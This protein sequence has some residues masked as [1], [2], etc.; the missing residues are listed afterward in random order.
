MN[1]EAEASNRVDLEDITPV[2]GSEWRLMPL[3]N[4]ILLL[5]I[6]ETFG[7][8]GIQLMKYP[9]VVLSANSP[10]YW[11]RD[12]KTTLEELES[13]RA[14][15]RIE[16][17][18]DQQLEIARNLGLYAFDPKLEGQYQRDLIMK[19][20]NVFMSDHRS[21][22]PTPSFVSSAIPQESAR[23]LSAINI[24]PG[25][26]HF[27]NLGRGIFG[28]NQK[29]RVLI[30]RP[31]LGLTVDHDRDEIL[32]FGGTKAFDVVTSYSINEF[33]ELG[34]PGPAWIDEVEISRGKVRTEIPLDLLTKI[35]EHC[36]S[37]FK[38]NL[39]GR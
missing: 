15:I 4:Q 27:F 37:C 23:F 13:E 28:E 19:E 1:L 11:K 22:F 34:L 5:R 29:A 8:E 3:R 10:I 38:E 21:S 9:R 39:D 2:L 24:F 26:Y 17:M 12:L 32:I 6:V 14:L 35:E 30:L 31:K 33:Q 16:F 7:L 20:P 36:P 18:S 25:P